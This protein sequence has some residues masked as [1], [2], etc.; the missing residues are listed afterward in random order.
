[1]RKNHWKQAW[2]SIWHNKKDTLLNIIGLSIGLTV[3][4]ITLLF[5]NQERSYDRWDEG[6]EQVYR[7]GVSE[8]GEDGLEKSPTVPYP[9]G[10]FL[11]DNY[12]EVETVSRLRASFGETLITTDQEKFYEKKIIL[13]DSNFFKLFPYHFIEGR[14]NSLNQPNTAVLTKAMSK[15]LFGSAESPIGKTFK[16]GP[17]EIYTV[18][19]VIEKQGPSHIN[20]DICLSYHSLHFANN[21]FMKNH[22]TYI[23]LNQRAK[24]N[25]LADKASKAYASHHALS[26]INFS[27]DAGDVTATQ[28]PTKWLAEERGIKNLSVFLEP[29]RSIHLQPEGYN[30]SASKI[31][32]YD[33]EPGNH[34]PLQVFAIVGILVLLLACINYTNMSI[35]QNIKRTKDTGVRKIMGA[36]KTQL[37]F[38]YITESFLICLLSLLLAIV[39]IVL[40]N[41]PLNT[42]FHLSL[43]IWNTLLQAQNFHLFIQLLVV[44]CITCIL[45]GFYPA[46]I[47]SRHEPVNIL[48][49]ISKQ[50]GSNW[51][52]KTLIILQYGIASCFIISM[53]VISAQLQFMKNNDPGFNT[54]QVLKIQP[55]QT[56]LFPGQPTDRSV[57]IKEELSKIAGVQRISTGESYPG[58]PPRGTQT[59]LY[60]Q[61]KELPVSF[62]L[63]NYDYFET[64]QMPIVAGRDF[65]PSYGRDSANAIVLNETA[66]RKM[67][68]GNPLGKTVELMNKSYTII[69]VV[70]DAFLTGYEKEILPQAYMMGVEEVRNFTGHS[71]VFIKIDAKQAG[72]TVNKILSFW[73]NQE[74]AY[75]VRYSWL[76]D[77]FAKLMEKHERFSSI[78]LLLTITAI[79]IATMGIFALSAFAIRQRTKEI[80]MRK[81]LGSSVNGIVQLLSKE[82]VLLVVVSFVIAIPVAWWSMNNWLQDFAYRIHLQ[83]WMF[84]LAGAVAIVI[85]LATV[86]YQ[87]IKA[88]VANPVK[89]LRTE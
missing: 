7:V 70:K 87:A 71:Q 23:K 76:D 40:I 35:A 62:S 86:C 41:E 19:G 53:I 68:G 10:T 57:F 52:R 6:L 81:I 69:G 56:Y 3:F 80:G 63:I 83:W 4:I 88:A 12:P 48:K 21:W 59:L 45:T 51:L 84:I 22:D 14:A 73:K 47:L 30:K 61:V 18:T 37:I 28:N 77:D 54:E 38:Q 32:V 64:L 27:D 65:S 46:Y 20:F 42:Y 26:Y 16:T 11:A 36:S 50:K 74:P 25:T 78:I 33:F 1:M 39:W 55:V 5:V 67:G 85:A 79:T 89:S 13:A 2:R 44:L 72:P 49:G 17:N 43:H 34:K 31:A 24:I 29:I 8:D 15:K 66:V 82:Y 58:M 9:L 75:P 60:E